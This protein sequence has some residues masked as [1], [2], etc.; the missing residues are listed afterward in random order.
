MKKIIGFLI[1]T[2]LIGT[3]IFPVTGQITISSNINKNFNQ[4]ITKNFLTDKSNHPI[5]NGLDE[6]INS[7]MV[8]YHI[9]GLSATIVKNEDIFWTKSYGYADIDKDQLVENTTLFYL[10]SVSKTITATAIMQLYE[11]DYF[12]LNDSI[13][14][15][16]P[17]E[18]NHPDHTSTNITFLMLLTHTSSIDDNPQYIYPYIDGDPTIPLGEFLE[19]YLTPGGDYYDSEENFIPQAPG[20][21]WEYSNAGVGLIGY[22]VEYISNVSFDEYC[23]TNIFQPLD[24]LETAWFLADLNIS[25]IAVPYLWNED[26]YEPYDHYSWTVYPAVNLRSS[27][28]QLRNF[29]MMMMNNGEYNSTQILLESTVELMFTQ[30]LEWLPLMGIIWWHYTLAGRQLWLHPGTTQGC[31][32][33]IAFYPVTNTGVI[34]LTNSAHDRYDEILSKL[35][36]FAENQAPNTPSNPEPDDNETD[37]NIDIELSWTGGDPNDGPVT[38]DVYFGTTSPPPKVES[39]QSGKTYNPGLL[40]FE[41]TYYWKIIAWDEFDLSKEGPV[42]S[43]TTEENLPPNTPDDPNPSDGATD[44]PIEKILRWTGGD[45]NSGDTVTYDVYFGK[46][47]PPPLVEEEISDTSYDPATVDLDTTYYWQIVA[48]DSQGLTTPG[49]IWS[50]TTELEPNEPPTEPDIDGPNEGSSGE[51]LCWD[52]HSDDPDENQIKYIIDWG[53]GNSSETDFNPPCTPVEVCHIYE[54]D[55]DY[56]ITAFAE[57]EKGAVSEESTFSVKVTT[58]RGRTVYRSLFYWLFERFP[59]LERL[60]TLFR[61]L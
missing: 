55:G 38:Y 23:E 54:V 48:E 36:D 13:N 45:P 16:L 8:T 44:V 50:F 26:E 20:T 12:E 5:N 47:S 46:S 1:M 6:Y 10:A 24:M 18:V 37:V 3:M 30:Q 7:E 35:F 52:F 51:E 32:T 33:V 21:T 60:L 59:L 39:N 58:P 61:V 15:Y 29:L 42:W 4:I 57:D 31:R 22:L 19:E 49:L 43:F 40:E 11:Q 14:D 34:L 27:V 28:T 2:L 41:T 9:P 56:V 17:F 25:N 53:D